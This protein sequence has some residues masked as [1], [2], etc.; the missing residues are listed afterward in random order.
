M[1]SDK[2]NHGDYIYIIIEGEPVIGKVV[3]KHSILLPRDKRRYDS[4]MATHRDETIPG[5]IAKWSD[6]GELAFVY[7]HEVRPA[8]KSLRLLYA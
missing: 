6:D 8:S 5:I 3:H 2:Y 1:L 7:E 4:I